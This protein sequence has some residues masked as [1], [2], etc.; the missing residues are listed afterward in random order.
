MPA[1]DAGENQRA[2]LLIG[3][4][5]LEQAGRVLKVC[6][7]DLPSKVP[8]RSGGANIKRPGQPRCEPGSPKKRHRCSR[9]PRKNG[10]SPLPEQEGGGS[11]AE[12][13]VVSLVLV[14]VE[15]VVHERPADARPVQRQNVFPRNGLV[16]GGPPHDGAPVK[17]QA[18][19]RLRPVRVALHERVGDYQRHHREAQLDALDVE[20]HEHAQAQGQLSSKEGEGLGG[21]QLPRRQRPL[22]CP[23]NLTVQVSIPQVVDGAPRCSTGGG[24]K[25]RGGPVEGRANKI[26]VQ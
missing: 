4:E 12:T 8:R 9:E 25:R 13:L 16:D 23:S 6:R 17:S 19:N 22:L 11:N 24:E 7:T 20:A 15:G 1:H 2:E 18:Q 14:A 5:N 10:L 21:S 26:R 3:P